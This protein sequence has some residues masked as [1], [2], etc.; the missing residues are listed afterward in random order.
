M[1]LSELIEQVESNQDLDQ[2]SANWLMGQIMSGNLDPALVKRIILGL[3]GKGESSSEVFGFV[4]AMLERTTPLEFDQ[5]TLD[6]VGTG[7]D[8]AG[9]VN[10]SSTAAIIAAAA[11]VLVVKHGNRAATSKSG[12]AD[13]LEALGIKLNLTA[14]QVINCV[15]EVGIGFCFAPQFHP[16]MKNVAPIR[17]EIGVPTIFNI[18]GPL[19]NPAQPKSMLIGVADWQRADLMAEVLAAKGVVGF[20]ARGDDGLDEITV[21]TT[22]TLSKFGNGDRV[23]ATFDPTQFGK[24]LVAPDLLAGGDATANA[25][26]LLDALTPGVDSPKVVA[27]RT[28]AVLNA[29]AGLLSFQLKAGSVVDSNSQNW[30][31]A[32]DAAENAVQSGAAIKI[33]KR[34]QDFCTAIN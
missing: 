19:A 10:I 9:T 16:A 27:I 29:A 28:A 17:K 5:V 7:G 18:L 3:K 11:G 32:I 12:S 23:E 30:Q 21:T 24:S 13:V 14:D 20:I 22:S 8:Q 6:I 2:S 25:K 31:N 15:G 26:Y 1:Q 33:L 4:N 34:W